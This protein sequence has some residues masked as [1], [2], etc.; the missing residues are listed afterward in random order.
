[1]DSG[2]LAKCLTVRAAIPIRSAVAARA[3]SRGACFPERNVGLSLRRGRREEE[4][5]FLVHE[6]L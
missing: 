4:D 5:A 1:M 6:P 2:F 3:G